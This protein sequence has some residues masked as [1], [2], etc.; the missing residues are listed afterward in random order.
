M[1]KNYLVAF[2]AI[3][4]TNSIFAQKMKADKALTD[5]L[6]NQW[7]IRF[8]SDQP[9]KVKDILAENIVEISGEDKNISRDSVMINFV[10]KRMPV[11]SELNAL[12]EFYSV[13]KKMIYTAGGYTLRVRKSENE[14]FIAQGNYSFVWVK[15]KDNRYRIVYIHIESVPKN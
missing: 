9:E 15:Q 3:I 5:S 12:N 7:N 2:I 13:S 14:S 8:N 6:V 11:I 4:I 1:R 10:E